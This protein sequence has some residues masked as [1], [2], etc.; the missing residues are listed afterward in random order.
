MCRFAQGVERDRAS[1]QRDSLFEAT[2]L[3][4]ETGGGTMNVAVAGRERKRAIHLGLRAFPIPIVV[5]KHPAE[6]DVPFGQLGLEFQ[7]GL[8]RSARLLH[9]FGDRAPSASSLGVVSPRQPGPRDR[10]RWIA[11]ERLAVE[12]HAARDIGLRDALDVEATLQVEPIGFGI[13]ASAT[14]GCLYLGDDIATRSRS[15]VV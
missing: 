3:H 11:V 1:R 8:R 6:R 5:R 14:L 2:E 15:A 9:A 13:V 4:R 7:R 10:K 12:A